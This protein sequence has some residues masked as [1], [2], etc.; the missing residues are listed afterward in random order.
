MEIIPIEI[1]PIK[2][3]MIQILFSIFAAPVNASLLLGD[4]KKEIMKNIPAMNE[5]TS[6]SSNFNG[7][8]IAIA[9]IVTPIESGSSVYENV[10]Q[11]IFP[12]VRQAMAS[13][14]KMKNGMEYIS[15]ALSCLKKIL[16]IMEAKIIKPPDSGMR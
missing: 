9:L 11:R 16:K 12:W 10:S 14:I 8:N 2:N 4:I 13:N 7:K 6:A 1:I 15:L 5:R 3:A